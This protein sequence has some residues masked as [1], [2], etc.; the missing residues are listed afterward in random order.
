MVLLAD[1]IQRELHALVLLSFLLLL[2]HVP[3]WALRGH[4]LGGD[5]GHV[6]LQ[7]IQ[8]SFLQILQILLCKKPLNHPYQIKLNARSIGFAVL[9][10]RRGG[11]SDVREGTPE[12]TDRNVRKSRAEETKR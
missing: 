3:T 5:I 9:R 1:I 6:I 8:S 12:S 2:R 11:V 7:S 10:G 4:C